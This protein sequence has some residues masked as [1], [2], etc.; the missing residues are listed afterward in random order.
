MSTTMPAGTYYL[1]DPCYVI[2]DKNWQAFLDYFEIQLVNGENQYAT[3][4]IDNHL[5]FVAF[6]LNGDGTYFDNHGNEFPCDAGMLG[7]V[8][9]LLTDSDRVYDVHEHDLGIIVTFDKEFTVDCHDGIIYI[10]NHIFDT[11][12]VGF[13]VYR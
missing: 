2:D 10:G 9:L 4:I 12:N 7:C 8:P 6:T 11:T 5:T 3:A 13:G 1:G